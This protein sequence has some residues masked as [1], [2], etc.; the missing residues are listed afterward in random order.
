MNIYICD[1]TQ[2]NV[3][4]VVFPYDNIWYYS[5]SITSCQGDSMFCRVI[6]IDGAPGS[7]KSTLTVATASASNGAEGN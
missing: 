7:Q 1:N 4:R 5:Y 3:L 6:L 2:F